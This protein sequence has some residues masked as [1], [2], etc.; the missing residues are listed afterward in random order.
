[1]LSC[2][3]FVEMDALLR[4]VKKCDLPFGGGVDVLI[5]GDFAQLPPVMAT[6]IM[7]ALVQ[8]THE[9]VV[10]EK[11]VLLASKL[12]SLFIKFDLTSLLR[13]KGCI[14]LKKLLQKYRAV[15]NEEPSLTMEQIKEIGIID[16]GTFRDD[17]SF[18]E[19]TIIVTAQRERDKLTETMAQI[20]TKR[21]GIP[22]YW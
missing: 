20:W 18:R 10:P 19:A 8:C 16:S 21:K 7:T 2:T 11:E 4:R 5:V 1:M 14:K 6:S 13:S 12:G 17:S 22:L 3:K 15:D 9:H